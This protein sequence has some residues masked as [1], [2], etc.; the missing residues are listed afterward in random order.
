[1]EGTLFGLVVKGNQ[2]ETHLFLGCRLQLL[3]FNLLGRGKATLKLP[4][5]PGD[6]SISAFDL[7]ISGT[8]AELTFW[9]SWG[10]GHSLSFVSDFS[11]FLGK[12]A[13]LAN[14]ECGHFGQ[15]ARSEVR[16]PT[17]KRV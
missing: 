9:S 1:M 3:P 12:N 8:K 11:R 7:E 13:I 17:T 16:K 10:P 4:G 5:P 6:R 15:S 2:K 14:N